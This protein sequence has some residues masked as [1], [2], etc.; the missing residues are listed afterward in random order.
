VW[1]WEESVNANG[2]EGCHTSIDSKRRGGER[3]RGVP[4][5][6]VRERCDLHRS[7]HLVKRSRRESVRVERHESLLQRKRESTLTSDGGCHR[8]TELFG[9]ACEH[10][11]RARASEQ[12][13]EQRL[14]LARTRR[15][16]NAAQ[17]QPTH[18]SGEL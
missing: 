7:T 14:R 16:V 17:R 4:R 8:A 15:L 18:T 11:T 9:V 6:T 13:R 12:Q 10:D 5:D 3:E 1:R 2:G